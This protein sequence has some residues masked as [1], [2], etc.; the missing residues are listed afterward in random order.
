MQSIQLTCLTEIFL[1]LTGGPVHQLAVFTARP[2]LVWTIV[3][4]ILNDNCMARCE[5]RIFTLF[6]STLVLSA[7]L[8]TSVRLATDAQR[9]LCNAAGQLLHPVLAHSFHSI[10]HALTKAFQS[11]VTTIRDIAFQVL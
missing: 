2:S 4:Q 1:Y 11:I 6:N 8:V 5:T 3:S 9:C 7:V 10:Q